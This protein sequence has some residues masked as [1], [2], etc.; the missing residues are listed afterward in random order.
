MK[1][2]IFSAAFMLL[3]TSMLFSQDKNTMHLSLNDCV[4]LA[5]EKNINIQKAKIDKE[6]SEYKIAETRSTLLPQANIGGSFQDNLQLP[7]T[8]LPG[9]LIGQP[10]TTLPVQMGVQYNTSAALTVNQVLYNQTALTAL[11]LS[12]KTD[13]M[14][15]LGIE[16]ASEELAQEVSKLYFLALTSAEQKALIEENITRTEKMTGITKTL[17]DNGMGKKVDYDRISVTLAN[18]QTQ[19]NNTE[20]LYEQQLNMI[21]YMLEIPIHQNIVLTDTTAMR[22]LHTEPVLVTDFS[23]HIDIQML[24]SQKDITLL[25]QKMINNGYL[26]SLSFTGQYAYQGMRSE[27]KNYFNSSVENNWYGSSYVG[28]NL[29][30]PIFDGFEKRSKSRQARLEY[31]K[32]SLTL[33]N[34]KERFSVEYKNAMNNYYNNK[35]NVARQKQNIDLAEKVYNETALRYREGMSTM[36]DLLQDEIGLSNAQASYLNALY[37]FKEAELQIMSLTGEN[38]KLVQN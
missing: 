22:L 21:K 36:S 25:N 37:N 12:K 18:F 35:N 33:D 6:K 16:K 4:Q 38:R 29:S 13:D 28:I 5:V 27:F 14:N 20:A 7:T 15:R 32:S 9:E 10:G 24:E 19:L 3:G 23:D 26:P 34:T 8:I 30:I 1:T 11:R 2:I 17:V 31:Q